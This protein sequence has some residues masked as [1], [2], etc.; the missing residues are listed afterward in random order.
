[1]DF[2]ACM[3]SSPQNLEKE[4][5]FF[6]LSLFFPKIYCSKADLK[7][8]AH[9]PAFGGLLHVILCLSKLLVC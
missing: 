2:I 1:M 4:I 3:S 8:C 6:P 5:Y 9:D 7:Y